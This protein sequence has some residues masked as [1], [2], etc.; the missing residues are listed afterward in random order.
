MMRESSF[1]PAHC[2]PFS[3]K[4]KFHPRLDLT[5]PSWQSFVSKHFLF[6]IP[7][8]PV[9]RPKDLL[10]ENILENHPES[11][12]VSPCNGWAYSHTTLPKGTS[13]TTAYGKHMGTVM[14][15]DDVTIPR[16]TMRGNSGRWMQ[17]PFMSITP[18]EIF[19]IR[20]GTRRAK[21]DVVIGGM[22]MCYQLIQV[23]HRKKVKKLRVVELSQGLADWL[24]P[25]IQ[26][27]LGREVELIVGNAKKLIPEMEAD[28]ALVDIWASYGGN[29]MPACPGIDYVWCWGSQYLD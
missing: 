24:W 26:P 11:V 29:K 23:S 15:D 3:P 1:D 18:M 4:M 20:G 2:K 13:L 9:E 27:R 12:I 6:D 5:A 21:G 7:S 10:I 17:S 28:V 14:F 19:T 16:V 8:V 25:V 22:G